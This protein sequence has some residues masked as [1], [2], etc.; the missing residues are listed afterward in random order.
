M[1]APLGKNGELQLTVSDVNGNEKRKTANEF[2]VDIGE[3]SF[4]ISVNETH[5]LQTI[6]WKG[7]L[8][9]SVNSSSA[10]L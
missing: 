4:D 10:K 6:C 5:S 3:A 2:L 9:F 7:I 8:I 1:V